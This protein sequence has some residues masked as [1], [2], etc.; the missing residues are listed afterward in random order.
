MEPLRSYL[1]T[2][3]WKKDW[4]KTQ[5]DIEAIMPLYPCSNGLTELVNKEQGNVPLGIL[6]GLVTMPV[7]AYIGSYIGEGLGW[8][9]GNIID[10]IPLV[11]DVAPWMAERTGLIADAKNYPNLN[12]DLYQASGAVSGFWGGMFF[13]FKAAVW[14]T[15]D[16]K[17]KNRF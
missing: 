10:I 12:E 9:S 11:N 17:P 14:L 15:L 5:K 13:P 16:N 4:D 7:C 3:G 1:T 6:V 8:L 2:K